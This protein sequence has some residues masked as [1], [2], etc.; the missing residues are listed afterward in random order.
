MLLINKLVEL[1]LAGCYAIEPVIA[2]AANDL[3]QRLF[4]R[5]KHRIKVNLFRIW[6]T[7]STGKQVQYRGV[8]C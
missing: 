1:D 7:N 3:M 8:P 5:E 2:D 6:I 4:E